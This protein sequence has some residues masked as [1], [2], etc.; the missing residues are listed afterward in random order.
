[1]IPTPSAHMETRRQWPKLYQLDQEPPPFK[2]YTPFSLFYLST[3]DGT[4]DVLENP[5][6]LQ[7]NSHLDTRGSRRP[8]WRALS[9]TKTSTPPL[10]RRLRGTEVCFHLIFHHSMFLVTVDVF[11]LQSYM[12]YSL[13]NHH[14]GKEHIFVATSLINEFTHSSICGSSLEHLAARN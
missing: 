9:F 14:F 11:L 2:A 12:P 1:M 7:R 6:W 10:T 5:H 4:V 8:R 13:H 3:R